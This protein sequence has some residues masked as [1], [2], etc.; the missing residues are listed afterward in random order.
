MKVTLIDSDREEQSNIGGIGIYNKRLYDFLTTHGHQVE[1]LR[2]SKIKPKETYIHQIPYYLAEARTYIFIPSEKALPL[3]RTHLE[4]FQPDIIY[5]S[6]GISPLDFFLPGLCRELSIPLTGVMHMDFNHSSAYQV[7]MKSIFMTY[8][9]VCKELDMLHVFSQ[10]LKDFWVR[11]GVV[12]EKILVLPN[13]V[14]ANFYTPGPSHFAKR[15]RMTD[16]ILFLGRLTFQKNPEVLIK[17]FLALN[18]PRSTKLVIIGQG[19]LE[20][21]LRIKYRNPRILFTG[22]VTQE[23]QKLDIIRSCSIFVLPSSYEGMSLALLEAMATGLACITTDSGGCVEILGDT[24]I[25]I[26]VTLIEK[27]LPSQL[28]SLLTNRSTTVSLGN[29]ARL[30]VISEYDQ[31]RN[32]T[33]LQ[34]AFVN[35][36]QSALKKF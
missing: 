25:I 12:T 22:K 13:G 16:G 35:T 31:E 1:I 3:I 32:F 19:D 29:R 14:D 23:S 36:I 26:P 15:H 24:G 2:F 20:K 6:L 18:P 34:T 4:R 21:N 11:K 30:R 10:K 8:L 7:L 33:Q 17:S 5:T 27:E 28:N 9:S